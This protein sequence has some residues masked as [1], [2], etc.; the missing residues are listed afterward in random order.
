ERS[1]PAR[2]LARHRPG[3]HRTS[4]RARR[5]TRQGGLAGRPRHPRREGA[6]R[7]RV[8]RRPRP[9]ASPARGAAVRERAGRRPG[10]RAGHRAAAVL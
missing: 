10:P 7:Q 1:A 5:G 6:G 8:R 3:R 2:H 9:V 4:H